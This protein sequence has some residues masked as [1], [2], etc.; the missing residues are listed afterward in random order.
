MVRARPRWPHAGSRPAAASCPGPRPRAGSPTPAAWLRT[1]FRWISWTCSTGIRTLEKSRSPCSGRRS[2]R[3]GP[4]RP[5]TAG[6]PP[7]SRAGS[8]RL[9]GACRGPQPRPRSSADFHRGHRDRRAGCIGSSVSTD[10]G[11]PWSPPAADHSDAAPGPAGPLG[12][13][14]VNPPATGVRAAGGAASRLP[15]IPVDYRPSR[16]SLRSSSTLTSL[17]GTTITH[18]RI[19][20]IHD[21]IKTTTGPTLRSDSTNDSPAPT[22]RSSTSSTT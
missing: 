10:W 12:V 19:M 22:P 5:T 17:P 9:T 4:P 20:E 2:D 11:D 6:P 13:I 7:R 1:M 18:R 14:P 3:R 21:L 16:D 15:R 8:A